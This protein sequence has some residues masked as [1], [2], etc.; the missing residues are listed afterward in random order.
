MRV[1]AALRLVKSGNLAHLLETVRLK[2]W[3]L[4]SM[5]AQA[6]VVFKNK[7]ISLAVAR[8]SLNICLRHNR[9]HSVEVT[10]DA[11]R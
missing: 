7:Y 4:R 9:R 8:Y 5:A 6:V 10:V 3:R 11:F 2:M 1:A